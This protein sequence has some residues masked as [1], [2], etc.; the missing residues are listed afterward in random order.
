MATSCWKNCRPMQWIYVPSLVRK[1]WARCSRPRSQCCW[2]LIPEDRMIT[3]SYLLSIYS[4][5]PEIGEF[6]HK[7]ERY[8]KDGLFAGT[9]FKHRGTSYRLISINRK[10]YFAHRLAWFYVHGSWPTKDIDHI[11]GNGMDN[12]IC[13]LREA[14]ASQ[15][16]VNSPAQ[17][18]SATGQRGIHVH[19][20]GRY[21]VQ[22]Q[23][24]NR[25]IHVGYFDTLQSAIEAR[26]KAYRE[27]HGEFARL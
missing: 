17:R 2:S 14:T 24:D 3:H 9:E 21:R 22:L 12:R 8:K 1:R 26:D 6:S 16:R 20:C 15:N 25:P 7:R 5:D 23:K 27:I 13:N 11:N 10:T 19:A 4:Y 18:H